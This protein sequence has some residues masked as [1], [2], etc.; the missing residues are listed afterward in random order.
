MGENGL[1]K[2][3]SYS[4]PDVEAAVV[5]AL[6]EE[7]LV[8]GSKDNCTACLVQLQPDGITAAPHARELIPGPWAEA[9]PDIRK[10]YAEF[11]E[12][13]GFVA[14]ANEVASHDAATAT[15]L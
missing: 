5:Q 7:C 6:L 14:E 8:K 10:K 9:P 15:P 2:F 1:A 11:F 3:R 4:P 12:L 13:E